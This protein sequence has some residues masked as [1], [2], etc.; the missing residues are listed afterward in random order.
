[1]ISFRTLYFIVF[2]GGLFSRAGALL[3][4]QVFD[5]SPQF[6]FGLWA[7]AVFISAWRNHLPCRALTPGR[8]QDGG[9]AGY[10]YGPGLPGP[11]QPL[12]Q[13][14]AVVATPLAVFA[15]LVVY[16]GMFVGP[17]FSDTKL[18]VVSVGDQLGMQGYE[19]AIT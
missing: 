4:G 5:V 15:H 11:H 7:G 2:I 8:H 16:F 3:G 12:W 6:F 18:G 10:G 14:T 1:M 9:P 13:R 19:P 17:H